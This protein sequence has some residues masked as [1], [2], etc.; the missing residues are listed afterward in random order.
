MITS[1]LFGVGAMIG[2]IA[3]A[4]QTRIEDLS[5]GDHIYDHLSGRDSPI[6]DMTVRTYSAEEF[7]EHGSYQVWDCPNPDGSWFLMAVPR[8]PDGPSRGPD[9]ALPVPAGS[10]RLADGLI[11]YRFSTHR[12]L[13]CA[14][15]TG[16]QIVPF[17]RPNT[18]G[19]YPTA[20]S[21]VA[22]QAGSGRR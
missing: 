19:D 20:R 5:V 3:P 4:N 14:V 9:G 10:P 18:W 15:G 13:T 16:Y 7:A 17:H 21:D 1:C 12:T 2:T 11:F 6:L 8:F 22:M